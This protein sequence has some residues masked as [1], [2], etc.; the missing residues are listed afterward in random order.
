MLIAVTAT[1]I[2]FELPLLRVDASSS[3][4][5]W[6]QR[7]S[8][9]TAHTQG[10]KQVGR[11]VLNPVSSAWQPSA[12]P[13]RLSKLARKWLETGTGKCVKYPKNANRIKIGLMNTSNDS[14]V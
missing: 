10:P 12:L 5:C 2:F 1:V 14:G 9:K 13:I 11:L 6:R 8:W 4:T 7:G 3:D